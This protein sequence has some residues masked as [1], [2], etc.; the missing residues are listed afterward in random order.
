MCALAQNQTLF[1]FG[2]LKHGQDNKTLGF[3]LSRGRTEK[4][5]RLLLTALRGFQVPHGIKTKEMILPC[6]RRG[7]AGNPA[8]LRHT[9]V[10]A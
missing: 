5:C 10:Y 3:W 4:V 7:A 2:G 6:G 8:M 9:P 1:R